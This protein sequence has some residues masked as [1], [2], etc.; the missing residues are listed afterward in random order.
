MHLLY[1]LF[2]LLGYLTL[3]LLLLGGLLDAG[4]GSFKSSIVKIRR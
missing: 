2:G 3:R 1:G 4:V